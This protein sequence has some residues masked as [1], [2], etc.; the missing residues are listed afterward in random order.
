MRVFSPSGDLERAIE[1]PFPPAVTTDQ[2]M[3]SLVAEIRSLLARDGLPSGVIQQQVEGMRS[4]HREKGRFRTIQF[5]DASGL[6]A[7]WQQDP[8]DIGGSPA[9]LHLLSLE[10]IYL[11]S[12]DYETAWGD[13]ALAGG[14][15][16]ILARDPETDLVTLSAER[17]VMPP[18]TLE[19]ASSLAAGQ[20]GSR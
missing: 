11:A 17:V 4:L 8:E 18:G 2:E 3:D 9:T 1:I 19:R 7:L 5:D 15:L 10:G 12:L 6:A 20:T 13:F 14:V 16:Y